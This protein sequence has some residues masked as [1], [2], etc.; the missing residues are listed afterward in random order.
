MC[1]IQ[2]YKFLSRGGRSVFLPASERKDGLLRKFVW[3]LLSEIYYKSAASVQQNS[4]FKSC[5]G[6][7]CKLHK[8]L[9][10]REKERDWKVSETSLRVSELFLFSGSGDRQK[11]GNRV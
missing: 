7:K 6:R 3:C 4:F 1:L 8:V 2:Q 5:L 11:L 9:K 10:Q